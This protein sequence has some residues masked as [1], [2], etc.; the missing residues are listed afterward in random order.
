M[1]AA[2]ATMRARISRLMG[3]SS[4]ERFPRKGDEKESNGSLGMSCA[5]FRSPARPLRRMPLG[6]SANDEP[7]AK[8]VGTQPFY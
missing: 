1:L 6:V 5:G 8:P 7:E 4:V 2:I 3:E